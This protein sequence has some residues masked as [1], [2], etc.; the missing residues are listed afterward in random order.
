MIALGRRSA[1]APVRQDVIALDAV[2]PL[3]APD[4][5]RAMVTQAQLSALLS[6]RTESWRVLGGPDLPV[7][8]HVLSGTEQLLRRWHSARLASGSV[9]LDNAQVLA[10]AV[11]RDPAALGIGLFSAIGNSTPLV[12][13]GTCGLA[14]PAT[15]DTIRSEDYP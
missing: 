8:V 14:I 13:G 12:V 10:D 1:R 5:P 9:R 7:D 11:T 15:R 2:V 3:V 6:G 4:N